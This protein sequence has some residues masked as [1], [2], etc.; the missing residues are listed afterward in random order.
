MSGFT[1]SVKRTYEFEGDQVEVVLKR[2]KRK[3]FQKWSQHMKEENGVVKMTF[4]DTLEM[5]NVLFDLLPGY[6][7]SFTGLKDGEGNVID[8]KTALEEA[9]FTDLIAK[10]I[11]D[12]FK[13][14]NLNKEDAK[15]S[16]GPSGDI[17]KA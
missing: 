3:D 2:L 5:G 12:L 14:S 6:I 17:S 13:I 8:L 10:V 9:Y 1:P 11:Q 15:N 16:G 7:T 4:S